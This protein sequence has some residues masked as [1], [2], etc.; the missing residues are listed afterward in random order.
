[1]ATR[2]H[3]IG[4]VDNKLENFHANVFLR[5]FRDALQERGAVV[6]GCH[7][8]DEAGGQEWATKNNVPYFADPDELNAQVDCFMILAPSNPETHLD[9]CRK[10]LPFG[11]PT[12][13]DKTFAPDLATAKQIF[14]LADQHATAVQTTSALRYTT[15]QEAL[16]KMGREN[17]RHMVA[18]G[19]GSSFG[20]YA[21]HPLELIVSCMGSAAQSLLR[22]DDGD[23]VQLLINFTDSRT[24]VANVYAN[25]NTPFAASLTTTEE[26][27]YVAVDS[28]K[29]FVN[30]AA[31]VLDFFDAGKP[32]IDRSESLMIRRILDVA[33]DPGVRD[34]FVRL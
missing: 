23:R 3:R 16:E 2:A 34:R 18:W 27:R 29:I 7:A 5:S 15:V 4:F 10:F 28:S 6:T 12:Y 21:I 25:A 33:E 19:G 11:K 30:T 13:V 8:L 14:E 31:A 1:M 32:Q 22:R 24:A 20:E 9:L 26:T 17:L